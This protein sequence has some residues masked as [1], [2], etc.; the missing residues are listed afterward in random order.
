LIQL[1]DTREGEGKRKKGKIFIVPRSVNRSIDIKANLLWDKAEYVFAGI[2]VKKD[3]N[4]LEKQRASFISRIENELGEIEPI[5]I[6]INFLKTVKTERL[7]RDLCWV[8]IMKSNLNISFRYIDEKKLISNREDVMKKINENVKN[9]VI[10]ADS[11]STGICLISG[12]PGVIAKTHNKTPINRKNNSLISFQKQCGYDSY[13]REQGYNAP[14]SKSSE[15]AYVT[16]LNTLLKS[17]RQRFIIGDGVYICW[18]AKKTNFENQFLMLFDDPETRDNP[19]LFS[20]NVKNLFTAID[21]GAYIQDEGKQ[22]FYLLGLSPGGGT[23]IS[24]RFWDT[25]TIAEYSIN[26]RKYFDELAIVKPVQ[27]PEFF[28]IWRLLV[29]VAQQGKSENI[30]PQMAGELVR[31]IICGLPFPTMLLQAALRRIHAGIKKKTKG[32]VV[33]FERVTPEIAAIIKAYLNRFYRIYNNQKS[34]EVKM[35][36]DTS[37]PSIGYQ[38]GRLF[39][40]LEKIQ[41]EANRGINSTIRERFYGAACSTPVTV[42]TNLLRLKNHHIAKFESKG[43]KIYFERLLGEIISKINDFPSYL[44]LHEQGLFAIGYYHQRQAFFDEKVNKQDTQYNVG[45]SK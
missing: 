13:R 32:G 30:P 27:Y 1:E 20:E 43:R 29:S 38:L 45:G 24:V 42:F 4:R 15:Y 41:G 12:I 11:K 8:E 10:Q 31:A 5:K 23:R 39:A 6:L 34:M 36:L 28:S 14:I 9:E 7:S 33:S 17:K 40:I 2:D 18:S 22:R 37:H 19:D 35:S 26:I 25:R 44:N 21:S 16:A 3:N